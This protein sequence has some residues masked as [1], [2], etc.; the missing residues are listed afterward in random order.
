MSTD[1]ASKAV[2]AAH[3][4]AKQE[5]EQRNLAAHKEAKEKRRLAGLRAAERRRE[6]ERAKRG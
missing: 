5:V 6:D 3:Q 4:A 1:D 2:K